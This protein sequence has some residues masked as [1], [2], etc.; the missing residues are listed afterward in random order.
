MTHCL[1]FK[2]ACNQY[3]NGVIIHPSIHPSMLPP[4]NSSILA[5]ICPFFYPFINFASTYI[6][7][8]IIL[9]TLGKTNKLLASKNI[10]SQWIPENYTC[11]IC[12]SKIQ[13]KMNYCND[14][15]HKKGICTMCGKKVVDTSSHR[16][17]LT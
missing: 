5:S 6:L 11:K 4:I 14:C 16:M 17:T 15:A 13:L 9:P 7:Y 8:A 12:K 10:S 2:I 1:N 3:L